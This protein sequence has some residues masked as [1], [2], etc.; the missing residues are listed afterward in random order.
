MN[1]IFYDYLTLTTLSNCTMSV[2]LK[3]T[4]R[5]SVIL[6]FTCDVSHQNRSMC[7]QT[8]TKPISKKYLLKNT[9]WYCKLFNFHRLFSIFKLNEHDSNLLLFVYFKKQ[10][11]KIPAS[12]SCCSCDTSLFLIIKSIY[13]TMIFTYKI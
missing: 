9:Y 3:I 13:L 11:K 12:F 2:M 5:R 4:I 7:S 8:F 1:L 6:K 10:I